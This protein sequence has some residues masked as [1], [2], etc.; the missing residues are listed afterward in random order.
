MYNT[1]ELLAKKEINGQELEYLLSERKNERAEFLLIDVREEYEYNEKRIVGVD[2]LVPLSDFFNKV[3]DI[4]DYKSKPIIAK[5]KLGGRS[6]QA[7]MHLKLLGF[8]TV[9]NL[10]G[11]I[12]HYKGETI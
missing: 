11:G 2:Y 10:S 4:E 7:Q 5:C 1:D 12:T 9:I 3:Q 6:A 8:E